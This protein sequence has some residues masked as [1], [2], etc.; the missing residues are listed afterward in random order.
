MMKDFTYENAFILVVDDIEEVLISTKNTLK[1]MGMNVECIQ[2]PI[3]AL[4]FLKNNKVDVLLLDFYMPQM[5]GDKF[6]E[7]LREFNQETIVILRT[8]YSDQI[9]P[10]DMIDKLNIQGYMDKAKGRDEL[11]LMTKSAI[12]TAFLNKR[13]LEKEQE[14]ARVNYKKALVEDL[15]VHLVNEAKDQLFQIEGINQ[16]ISMDSEDYI[17]ETKIVKKATTKIYKLFDALNFETQKSMNVEQ[18]VLTI[19]ELL[20]AK[21]LVNN[22]NLQIECDDNTLIISNNSDEL[23]YLVLKIIDLLVKNDSKE[24]IIRIG[25]NDNNII[26]TIS[27]KNDYL[28]ID[29]EELEKIHENEK[30][31]IETNANNIKLII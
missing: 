15:I 9:P 2:N 7:K 19:K 22:I 14:I 24:I 13:I 4:E 12:K 21:M 29:I 31:K 5:N 20:K 25:E 1:F 10:L 26:F 27:N 17:E 11:I 6:I 28:N 16:A 18:I 3:E 30:V 8:G 23:I